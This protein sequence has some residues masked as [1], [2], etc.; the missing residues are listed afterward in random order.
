MTRLALAVQLGL[1]L[2]V[3]AELLVQLP[4]NLAPADQRPQPYA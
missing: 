3:K 1:P 2:D 4:L